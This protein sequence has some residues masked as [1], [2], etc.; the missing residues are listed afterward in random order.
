MLQDIMQTYPNIV[1]RRHLWITPTA[2]QTPFVHIQSYFATAQALC[3]CFIS[4]AYDHK[5]SAKHSWQQTP[6][7]HV[8]TAFCWPKT[9]TYVRKFEK[10]LHESHFS[11]FKR[12][13]FTLQ[14]DNW[15]LPPRDSLVEKQFWRCIF[16][17]I[18]DYWG[19]KSNDS[20]PPQRAWRRHHQ[21][22][23]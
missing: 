22:Y 7:A 18:P 20:N 14:D 19:L 2:L 11:S 9:R 3:T 16:F 8:Q 5:F 10:R 4:R 1:S 23:L 13:R 6:C 15:K 21:V 17:P 12:H